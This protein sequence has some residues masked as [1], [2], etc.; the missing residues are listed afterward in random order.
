[1]WRLYARG[2]A[3]QN[4]ELAEGGE[5]ESGDDAEGGAELWAAALQSPGAELEEELLPLLGSSEARVRQQAAAG[6]AAACELVPSRLHPLLQRL[7]ALYKDSNTFVPPTT[8]PPFGEPEPSDE[9]WRARHGV[10]LTLAAVAPSLQAAAQL[11]LVFAFLKRALADD[12][13]AVQA[14]LWLGLIRVRVRVRADPK[15]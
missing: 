15:N 1:M 12:H 9:G 5:R 6:L 3:W 11:P 10:G 14:Q 4:G 7:F 13:E 8:P 2:V